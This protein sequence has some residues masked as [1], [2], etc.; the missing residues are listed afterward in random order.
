MYKYGCCFDL[1]ATAGQAEVWHCRCYTWL[2]ACDMCGAYA[3][4]QLLQQGC[5]PSISLH[6]AAAHWLS[7]GWSDLIPGYTHLDCHLQA[8]V[9]R[10][11]A[12][13]CV[14]S[15]W[16]MSSNCCFWCCCRYKSIVAQLLAERTVAGGE[17][18]LEYLA[19]AAGAALLLIVFH[20]QGSTASVPTG[21]SY[22][23]RM[24]A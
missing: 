17:G 8:Q 2:P 21:H 13:I 5:W 15:V 12:L 9:R 23:G 3:A 7:L 16:H 10:S 4:G 19:T 6:A 11:L 14:C 20:L 24:C 22:K 18:G 1:D